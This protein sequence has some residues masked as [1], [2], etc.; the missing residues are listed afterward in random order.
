MQKGFEGFAPALPEGCQ[1]LPGY[2]GPQEQIELARDIKRI[3]DQAP[4]F[5]PRM[6]RT[7]KPFSVRMS[8]CGTLGWVSDA[9]LGYRY[10]GTHPDN[11]TPWPAMP[12]ALL[13]LWKAVAGDAEAPEACLINYYAGGTK[14]GSHKDADEKDV[15]APVVSVSLGDE[16]AFHIGGLQRTDPKQRLRLGSG[17]V[18]V[19]GGRSRLA[20]HGIDRVYAGTSHLIAQAGIADGGRI[21]LTLR[22]V[23]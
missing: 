15:S 1:Y 14:M 5:Q 19:L 16:A 11:G 12:P 9:A 18:F 6:P 7:G 17:D 4:L 10:Q 23:G 8:N 21:N 2:F 22:R 20:F 3:L 13:A